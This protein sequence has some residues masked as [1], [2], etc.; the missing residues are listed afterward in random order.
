SLVAVEVRGVA[1]TGQGEGRSG[2]TRADL[3]EGARALSERR[4]QVPRSDV[5]SHVG[6]FGSDQPV[7]GGSG[8]GD[9][10]KGACRHH[11]R[12]AARR[13]IRRASPGTGLAN[14][15]GGTSRSR[16]GGATTCPTLRLIRNL[17]IT[18]DRSL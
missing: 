7:V 13:A 3:L 2:D 9:Q 1:A 14:R 8:Q 6:I 4:R 11:Q 17:R 16:S 5:E 12:S 18:W 10:R 15:F